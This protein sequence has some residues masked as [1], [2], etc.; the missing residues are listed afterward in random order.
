MSGKGVEFYLNAPWTVK[1]EKRTD[2]GHYVAVTIEE[3]PGFVVAAKSQGE[4]EQ[5][6]WPTL[7][8]FLQSYLDDGEEV[9]LPEGYLGRTSL[10]V[11]EWVDFEVEMF[12]ERNTTES[13]ADFVPEQRESW[14]PASV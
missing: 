12:G 4:I 11:P 2:D 3:L 8:D 13:R 7:T 1:T 10:S 14:T 9:P 6:F 5:V